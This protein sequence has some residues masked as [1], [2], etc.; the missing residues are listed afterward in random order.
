MHQVL[1]DRQHMQRCNSSIEAALTRQEVSV[2]AHGG[3]QTGGGRAG[4]HP[5]VGVHL[6]AALHQVVELVALR[7]GSM[8]QG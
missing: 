2:H 8:V 5:Q 1:K 3:S 6:V 4:H 7:N